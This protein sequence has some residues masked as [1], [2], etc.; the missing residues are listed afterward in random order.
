MPKIKNIYIEELPNLIIFGLNLIVFAL[1]IIL[2]YTVANSVASINI[3]YSVYS[4]V[5]IAASCY[6][7]FSNKK[8]VSKFYFVGFLV[9]FVLP[10]SFFLI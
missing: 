2:R 9:P 8:L 3:F 10:L 6:Y 5:S 4:I 1:L 7:V